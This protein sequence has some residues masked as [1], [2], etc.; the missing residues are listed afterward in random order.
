[1]MVMDVAVGGDVDVAEGVAVDV[2]D[3]DAGE[4]EDG[5]VDEDVDVGVD[6]DAAKDK[7]EQELDNVMGAVLGSG[8]Y[9]PSC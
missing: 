6:V 5:L 9:P 7:F 1:M 2:Q 8:R 3:V 4:D